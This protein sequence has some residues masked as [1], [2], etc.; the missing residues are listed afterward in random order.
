MYRSS[1]TGGMTPAVKLLLIANVGVYVVQVLLDASTGGLFTALFALN[2]EAIRHGA[3]WQ[4]VTYM[5][6]HG[7]LFHLLLNMLMLYF[8]GPETER[9]MGTRPFTIMYF[10]SGILAGAGWLLLSPTNSC[11]GASGA[12][13]GVLASFATLYPQRQITLLLF[14]IIPMTMKAWVM[15]VGMVTLELVLLVQ[16]PGGGGIAHSAHLAGALVGYIFTRVLR[17]QGMPHF[18]LRRGPKLNVLHREPPPTPDY[19]AEVDRVL[20]KIAR[21]GVQSLNRSERELLE[22][23]SRSRGPR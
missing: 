23:A 20:D 4:F 7:P 8:I 5:F 21:E 11:Y 16:H 1:L 10:L 15:V 6:L 12:V 13:F 17:G 3:I 18:H 2:G 19:R 14:F 9:T 22:R